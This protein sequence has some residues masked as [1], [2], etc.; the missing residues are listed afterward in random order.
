MGMTSPSR[1]IRILE[2]ERSEHQADL[3]PQLVAE[4]GEIEERNQFAGSRVEPQRELRNLIKAEVDRIH[5][6][7]AKS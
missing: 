3:R 4:A 5:L 1:L 2:R 7:K 6:G